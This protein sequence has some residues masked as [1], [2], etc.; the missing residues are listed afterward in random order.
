M[1]FGG[2]DFNLAWNRQEKN[3]AAKSNETKLNHPRK[4]QNNKT[5]KDS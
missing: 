5:T 4:E 1:A 2:F 3:Q